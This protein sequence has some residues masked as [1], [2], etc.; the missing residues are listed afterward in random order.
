M[1]RAFKVV[2][3][4]ARNCYVVTSELAKRSTKSPKFGI[5]IIS[6]AVVA[7][8]LA[9]ILS[10]GMFCP[11]EA[12][13]TAIRYYRE[14]ELCVLSEYGYSGLPNDAV[15]ISRGTNDNNL[16]FKGTAE[17][18]KVMAFT[19]QINSVSQHVST[20]RYQDGDDNPTA[21]I[22]GFNTA[23]GFGTQDTRYQTY[24][25]P[26]KVTISDIDSL[27]ASV[28]SGGSS[29]FTRSDNGDSVICC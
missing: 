13:V 9:S 8:I 23:N 1:N 15:F 2:W 14:G 20:Y 19:N 29:D 17:Y 12:A 28:I 27:K 5:G 26:G 18:N 21:D 7:G 6:R 24:Y 3:S 10:F 4:K 25:I 16:Y 11:A 22:Y